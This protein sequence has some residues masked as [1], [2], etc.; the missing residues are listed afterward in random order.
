M[1]VDSYLICKYYIILFNSKVS[2]PLLQLL[3]LNVKT[4]TVK[5]S[6]VKTDDKN[7]AIQSVFDARIVRTE[8]NWSHSICSRL[9]IHAL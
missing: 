3:L 6:R 2:L 8:S 5:L 4:V 7:V 9:S 1:C